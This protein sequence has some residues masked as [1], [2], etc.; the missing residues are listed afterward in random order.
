[1]NIK[2]LLLLFCFL[3]AAS[4][5]FLKS[6]DLETEESKTQAYNAKDLNIKNQNTL[7]QKASNKP[8]N[9][10]KSTLPARV[11]KNDSN[12]IAYRASQ[13][14]GFYN[15]GSSIKKN[16]SSNN[17]PVKTVVLDSPQENPYKQF[18]KRATNGANSLD[19]K[20]KN[21]S[22]GELKD[23]QLIRKNEYFEKLSQQ[24]KDLRGKSAAKPEVVEEVN[25]EAGKALETE[26][27]VS[28][29][30]IEDNLEDLPSDITNEELEALEE[31]EL[32][33]Q[34]EGIINDGS[35][36]QELIEEENFN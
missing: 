35:N 27:E 12:K 34:E 24:L 21:L 8:V 13:L 17:A 29:N 33:E 11:S 23:E 32:L 1:M 9:V 14:G 6:S 36:A 2:F 26:K 3:F 4:W 25:Q 20:L 15:T 16:A 22:S 10:S 7:N 5:G 18:L 19:S 28:S 30:T 31:L